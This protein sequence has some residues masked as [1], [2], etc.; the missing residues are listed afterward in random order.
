VFGAFLDRGAKPIY[1]E[2]AVRTGKQGD[3]VLVVQTDE[4][5]MVVRSLTVD[6]DPLLA[7]ASIEALRGFKFRPYLL[8]RTPIAVESQ[9]EFRFALKGKGEH[10]A[11]AT[12]YTFQVPYRPEFRT[13]AVMENGVLVLPP[14]KI[15]GPDPM[16]LSELRGKSG[17]VYLKVKIGAAGKVEEVSVEGGTEA[18]VG[19]VVAAVKQAVYDPQ[20]VDGRPVP[21]TIEESYHFEGNRK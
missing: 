19:P 16:Q 6:G 11:G 13:G 20:L 15:S 7:A 3:V 12:D 9:I 5:G 4:K 18:L 10:A 21:A 17:S 1:P 8:N 14:K 2:E